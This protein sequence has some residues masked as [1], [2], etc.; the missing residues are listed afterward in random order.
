MTSLE[1]KSLPSC[2]LIVDDTQDDYV[3]ISNYIKNIPG[4]DFQTEWCDDYEKALDAIQRS[5]H[6]LYFIDCSFTGKKG[7]NLLN[8]AKV[9]ACD[10]PIVMLTGKANPIIDKKAIQLGASDF[11]VKS[12][13]DSEKLERC[14]RYSIERAANLKKLKESE[15]QYRNIFERTGDVIFIADDQ[16]KLSRVNDAAS[17]MFGHPQSKLIQIT[18][19]DLFIHE[20]DKELVKSRLHHDGRVDDYQVALKGKDANKVGLLSVS[21]ETDLKGGRYTQGIIHEITLLKRTEE[22]RIQMEKLET[23]GRVIRTLAHE[24][25][26]PLNNIQLSVENLKS[27]DPAE[28]AEYLEIIGRNSQRINDLINDLMDSTRY[29]KMQLEAAS[30]Q[31]VMDDAL[32]AVQDRLALKN[33]NLDRTYSLNLAMSL[34]DKEKL[35]IALTNLIINAIEAMEN[36]KGRINISVTHGQHFH[37]MTIADNGCGMTEETVQK[38]FEPYFTTKPKGLG[39]GLAATEAIIVSH[40]ATMD[41]SSEVDRGTVF[42]LAF[43]TLK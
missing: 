22:I 27:S 2:I 31:S 38:L 20:S 12:E 40:K 18:L 14:I 4:H 17:Q 1:H 30:L 42:T 23:K 32:Y 16:L 6:S 7:L 43:P 26:N 35:R 28:A 29:H 25:R 33:I 3:T 21:F 5:S 10:A 19:L 13:L 41:V 39:L 37:E 8:E 9:D 34:V 36:G 15:R 24:V 11:L